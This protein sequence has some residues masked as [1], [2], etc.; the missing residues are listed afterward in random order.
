MG[1][2]DAL[3]RAGVKYLAASPETMLAPGVPSAKVADELT[4]A[5]SSWPQAIVDD[6]MRAHY[7]PSGDVYHPAAAFDVF[8]LDPAKV[9]GVRTAVTAFNDAVAAMPHRGAAAD[10]LREIRA[11]VGSVRGMA[12]FPHSAGMPWHADRPAI[13]VYDRVAA[14]D[15]LPQVVRDAAKNASAAIGGIVLAHGESKDFAP[16][17]SSYAD[18]AGP[19]EHLPTV[20]QSYDSWADEGVSETHNG[21]FDAVD[22]R[23]FARAVGSYDAREDRAGNLA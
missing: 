22:G 23:E 8:D 20:R 6:T 19:T 11:D 21:F 5:A 12:R 13:A 2:I 18:A 17:G 16:F 3:S 10:A 9:A 7:G 1:F 15:R 14:D 4:C